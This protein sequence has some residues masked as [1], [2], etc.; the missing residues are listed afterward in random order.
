MAGSRASAV[1]H[2]VAEQCLVASAD[3]VERGRCALGGRLAEA[4]D[5]G[6][7]LCPEPRVAGRPAAEVEQALRDRR[8]RARGRGA[9]LRSVAVVR[10]RSVRVDELT[11][12]VLVKCAPQP[13]ASP[14]VT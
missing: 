14:L 4:L 1:P 7:A 9:G 5:A 11:A 12:S 2:Q 10:N 6:L 8:K 13:G 3:V